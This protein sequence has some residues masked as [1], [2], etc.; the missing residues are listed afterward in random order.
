MCTGQRRR[1][2]HQRQRGSQFRRRM[3]SA[4]WL[5][6]NGDAESVA[7]DQFGSGGLVSDTHA[8]STAAVWLGFPTCS[9]T[10]VPSVTVRPESLR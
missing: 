5:S 4:R 7:S 10:G 8:D 1:D 9:N 3:G 6:G 2:S